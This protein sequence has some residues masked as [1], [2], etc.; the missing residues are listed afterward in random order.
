MVAI[1]IKSLADLLKALSDTENQRLKEQNIT[2]PP[3]IGSMYEGLT[4]AILER[5]VF[6]GLNLVVS[7]SSFIKGCHTEFD[8]ILAEGKGEPIP[9]TDKY[10]FSREQVI[11][12]IQVKKTLNAKELADGYENLKCITDLYRDIPIEE[13]MLNL[14]EHAAN[15][16]LY[17]SYLD[18]ARGTLSLNESAIFDCLETEARSPVKIVLGYNGIKS[19]NS[20]R[21][22]YFDFIKTKIGES[23]YDPNSTPS[24]LICG[25]NALVKQMGVPYNQPV[26]MDYEGWWH[27]LVS[28]HYNPLYYI[29]QVLWSKLQFR[30]SLP[31][32]IWGED[33]DM[34]P[35]TPFLGCKYIEI[36]GNEGWYCHHFLTDND[37]LNGKGKDDTYEWQPAFLNMLQYKMMWILCKLDEFDYA[38][39]T[40]LPECA[41]NA[42]YE[43]VEELIQSLCETTLVARSGEGKIRL[44]TSCVIMPLGDKIVAA[45]NSS[46]RLER[47]IKKHEHEYLNPKSL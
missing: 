8:V 46:G 33:M 34:A 9:Y 42:G 4:A 47:W 3:T 5:T 21:R 44:A 41:L 37:I 17:R 32:S 19:E 25:K 29:I 12:V 13:Y 36:D 30:Y 28:S 10:L 27:F 24:L 22:K 23:G 26:Q 16:T 39:C 43:S 11:A 2:H 40:V 20:L 6:E 1:S 38:N 15:N 7:K 14:T 31:D 35:F 45:D 18:K